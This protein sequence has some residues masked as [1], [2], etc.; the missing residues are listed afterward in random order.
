MKRRIFSFLLLFMFAFVFISCSKKAAEE[1]E[2]V[3]VPINGK[4]KSGTYEGKATGY[5]GEVTATI[6][7]STNRIESITCIGEKETNGIGSVAITELPKEMISQQSVQVDA[8]TGATVT[9]TAVKEAVTQ[10]LT[11]AGVDVETLIPVNGEPVG[12]A[13]PIEEKMVVDLVVIGAGGAGMTA[14]LEAKAF[15]LDVIIL[16]KENRAGGNTLKVTSIL[17]VTNTSNQEYSDSKEVIEVLND[18]NHMNGYDVGANLINVLLDKLRDRKIKILYNTTATRLVMENGRMVGVKAF[19]VSKNYSIQSKAVIL[20]TGGFGANEVMI[21]K[22]N[23]ELAEYISVN[24]DGT[25]GD[26]VWMAQELGA[27]VIHMDQILIYPTVELETGS[28]I[29]HLVLEQGAIL[30]NQN[31]ERFFNELSRSSLVSKAITKQEGSCAYLI[32]D[33]QIREKVPI[34]EDY[35]HHNLAKKEDDLLMLAKDLGIDNE[36]LLQTVSNWNTNVMAGTIDIYNRTIGVNQ[37]ISLAPFY[38]IKVTPAIYQTF[39]GVEV[40]TKA[41]VLQEDRNVILGL[42]AAGEVIGDIHNENDLS[43]NTIVETLIFGQIAGRSAAEYIATL[44]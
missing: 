38:A 2:E 42:F 11:E 26:G 7:L 21:E 19:R 20:A 37:S 39:G 31:G 5:G 12:V 28:L 16:E 27:N 40:T 23:Q 44:K 34:I 1:K 35:L 22:F 30:V 3:Q 6:V 41:E 14:A 43:G 10:A 32:F 15:G 9:S 29:S 36:T 25:T 18:I 24:T 4:Y 17:D 8:I 13:T 33:Q